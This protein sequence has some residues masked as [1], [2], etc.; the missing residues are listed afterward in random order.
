MNKSRRKFLT[1]SAITIAGLSLLKSKTFASPAA[2]DHIVGIQLYSVR[3]DMKKDPVATLKQLSS[4]GYT[5]VEHA[6]YSDRK[7]YG[8]SPADF[9]KIL[10]DNG[11]LML[12]GHSSLDGNR[13]NK[14]TNDFTDEW[15]YTFEDASAVGMKYVISPKKNER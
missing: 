4:I 13:W 6:G 14:N 5:H 1:Q 9:K 12:S 11:L 15:K 10:S 8:Y 2:S 7:F 3:D